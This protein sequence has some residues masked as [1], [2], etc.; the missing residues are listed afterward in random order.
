MSSVFE[1]PVE[2]GLEF[3]AI[4]GLN[5]VDAEGQSPEDVVDECDGR[6]LIAGVEDFQ[7]ANAGAIVDRRELVEPPA[8]ARNALEKLDVDLQPMPRLRLLVARPAVRVPPVLLIRRQPV[9]AVPAQNAMHGGTRHREAVKP[10]QIIGNLARAEV[11]VLPE[12]EDLAHDL[13]RRRPRG[14]V[15]R[16]GPVR[17]SGITVLVIPLPPL[18]ERLPGDRE[19]PAG[20]RHIAG[21]VAAWSS[22]RRQLVNRRCSDFVIR[23]PTLRFLGLEGELGVTS[24]P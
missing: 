16:P 24:V 19:M 21:I 22:F 20:A 15:R 10:L 6:P 17:Q 1:M 9:H 3:G 23:S 5:D 18:V 2:V 12:V 13:W 11:V 7:H 8:R 14:V 4:V